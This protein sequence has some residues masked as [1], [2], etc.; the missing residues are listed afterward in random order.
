MALID[1]RALVHPSA[2]LGK[3]VSIGPFTIVGRGVEI[4]ES[5]RI[6]SHCV[7]GE[8]PG[9]FGE[10]D[11]GPLRIGPGA[12]IRSHSVLYRGSTFDSGLRTGH[13]V[14][15]REG[16]VAGRDLQV[17]TLCDLQGDTI[18]GECVRMHSN[19]HIGKLSRIESFAWIF[20][21][22]VL[23]ND[24]HPPSE[25]YLVGVHVGQYAVIATMT[26]VLPGV[27]IGSGAVVGAHALVTHDVPRDVVVAGIPARVIGPTHAIRL[28]DNSGPAYPW[29]RHFHRGY[30]EDVVAEWRRV[31]GTGSGVEGGPE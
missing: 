17:G 8:L 5:G 21:Y 19:V 12:H 16:I 2:L 4:G 11:V 26:T 15:L 22:V 24:P 7:L 14:T 29:M 30:P 20:P 28:R 25:G 10:N 6:E 1:E 13:R 27:R 3:D 23:T 31:Y 9:W 18:I